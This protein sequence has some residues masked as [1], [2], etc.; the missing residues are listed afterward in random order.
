MKRFNKINIRL[1]SCEQLT[2]G[3]IQSGATETPQI[4]KMVSHHISPDTEQALL[5]RCLS[6]PQA[7]HLHEGSPPK[8]VSI[9]SFY[10]CRYVRGNCQTEIQTTQTDKVFSLGFC[11]VLPCFLKFLHPLLLYLHNWN[12]PAINTVRLKQHRVL[13]WTA[14]STP[15]SCYCCTG[16]QTEEDMKKLFIC[17]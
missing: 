17:C 5:P 13:H 2:T 11:G 10:I 9:Q 7:N 1:H 15:P 14:Q 3:C 4:K 12:Y 6:L 8:T 16:R